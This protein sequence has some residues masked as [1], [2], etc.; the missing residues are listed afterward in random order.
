[1]AAPT[2]V[3]ALVHS[4]TL[5]TAGIYLSIRFSPFLE[6]AD[7][8]LPLALALATSLIARISACF[9]IDLK[10]IIALSTLRQLGVI[11]VAIRFKLPLIALFH[12]LAHAFFKAL[13]FV[14]AGKVIHERS[15]FQDIRS[16][17][18]ITCSLPLSA[19]FITLANLA[20]CGAPFLAGFF[21]KDLISE[22]LLSS[23]V[24]PSILPGLCLIIALSATY[25]LRL[26]ARRVAAYTALQPLSSNKEEDPSI[27][28]AMVIL[29]GL[30]VCRG[31]TL[32]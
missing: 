30:A 5:V 28:A 10:K 32:S 27:I 11:I 3:S 16:M 19:A 6:T 12:L 22:T 7:L 20:L 8:S 23:P 15:R 17:G 21:S 31:A 25:S 29:G 24:S 18:G 26:V 13:L 2:P 1:M 4:S 14:S 9:E